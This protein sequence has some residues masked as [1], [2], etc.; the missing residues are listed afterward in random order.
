MRLRQVLNNLLSNTLKFTQSGSVSIL[1]T[2]EV[3]EIKHIVELP[4][5]DTG[6][7][8]SEKVQLNVFKYFSQADVSTRRKYGGTGLGLSISR[9]LASV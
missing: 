8:V 3:S 5:V 9:K 2:A 6:I 1:M 7:G 4:V